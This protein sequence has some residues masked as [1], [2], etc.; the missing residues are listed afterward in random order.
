MEIVNNILGWV[1]SF[2]IGFAIYAIYLM[3]RNHFAYKKTKKNVL[4]AIKELGFVERVK[5]EPALMGDTFRAIN[6]W[7]RSNK[8]ATFEG[9]GSAFEMHLVVGELIREGKL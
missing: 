6:E 4:Q 9:R 5:T 1:V 3:V 8:C 7:L 2:I